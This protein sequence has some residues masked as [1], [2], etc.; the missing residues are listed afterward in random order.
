MKL[1]NSLFSLAL[2]AIFLVSCSPSSSN[3]DGNTNGGNDTPPVIDT[4]GDESH[5]H[6]Y[7]DEWSHDDYYHYH[8]CECHAKKDVEL[9]RW[10]NGTVTK[11]ATE[12]EDGNIT[13]TCTV[14]GATKDEV[15]PKNGGITNGGQLPDDGNDWNKPHK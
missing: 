12:T 11:E 13:Y 4:K 7:S 9:H 5:N 2:C 10:N 6:T 15:I 14:C 1:K 3:T 8:E